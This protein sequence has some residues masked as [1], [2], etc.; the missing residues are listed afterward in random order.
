[1][2]WEGNKEF[3]AF[4]MGASNLINEKRINRPKN[5]A[6]YFKFVDEYVNNN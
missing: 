6:K 5:L 2:Y 1:M 4:G 3:L